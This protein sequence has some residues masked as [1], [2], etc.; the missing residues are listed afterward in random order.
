MNRLEAQ[1]RGVRVAL[2][3]VLVVAVALSSQPLFAQS[4][5]TVTGSVVDSSGGSL[6]G[7]TVVLSGSGPS[8][9]TTTGSD[10]KFKLNG[11]PPGTYK[12]TVSLSGFLTAA[13][14]QVQ[15]QG[16][17]EVPPVTLQIASRG[18]DIV[19]TASKTESS[20]VNAPVSISVITAADLAAAPV[21]NFGDILRTVPGMN[22]IQMSAR[23]V[24]VT[25]REPTNTLSNSQLALVDGRTIYLDF[26]GL[27]LW[28]F[29]PT[30]SDEIKQIEV[31]R[32]PASVVWGANAMTGVVNIIT[33]SPREMEGGSV[34]VQGG[35][36]SRDAGSTAGE[37]SGGIFGIQAEFAQAPSDRI[38]YR[39]GGGYYYSDAYPRPIGTVPI[40][41]NPADPTNVVG[42][43][44]YPPY[45][46]AG[47]KQPRFDARLDQELDNGGR[48][49]YEGGYAGTS[50]IINSG[51]GP[52]SIQP[53]SYLAFG[54]VAYNQNAFKL[55][56]YGNFVDAKAP[57]L[58]QVDAATLQPLQ[59]NFTTQ[60]YDLD[61]ENANSIG[62]HNLLTYGGNARRNNFTITIAPNGQDRNEFGGYVQDEIFYEHIRFTLG[63]RVDKF[64]NL[65][66]A[67]FSPRLAAILKP[68]ATQSIRLSFNKAFRSPSLIN[69]YID[70]HTFVPVNLSALA[71]LLPPPLQGL[72]AQP[73]NLLVHSAG[74][75]V[76]PS[77]PTLQEESV[78]AYEIGY[79]GSFGGKTTVDAAF[80]INDH[81]NSINFITDAAVQTQNGALG[82]FY[83]PE[84][85]P[86]GWQ[87]PV[88]L[89]GLLAEQGILLPSQFT[90][91]NL[92]PYRQKGIELGVQETF[93]RNLS[94]FV[95]YSY[96]FDP[97]ILSSPNP[98]PAEKLSFPPTNRF[99]AGLNYDDRR[100][101]GTL[102]VNYQDKAFWTDVLNDPFHGFTNSYTMVNG[103][104][105]VK[106]ADGR[107][108]T[109][110]KAQN[111]GN[112][113]IQQH[114]FGDIIKRSVYG[115]V[116][117]KF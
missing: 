87:L 14:D 55:A 26:F 68:S 47:T 54:R 61:A 111:I 28:D 43:G 49:T 33:K 105:G 10:G 93:T 109:S 29:V 41:Q 53:G 113:D 6:P 20:V 84:N 66:H 99:N 15:V 102:S 100:F 37:G 16:A 13:V 116:R 59:L 94:G 75:N 71:P 63:A 83:T 88:Q 82:A 81:D 46:N 44:P 32:G 1:R 91:L 112:T 96:Q 27:I 5:G 64:S 90:Y 24:N 50:G 38:S 97:E 108:I 79:T 21:Q 103:S 89:I 42:G 17:T 4:G 73:F 18:E 45:P 65:D 51:I 92:G 78:K 57:N 62:A 72:V 23:D 110:I 67:V 114:I 19:V 69:N 7:A 86:P 95:N 25:S 70:T 85:P 35:G 12:V 11:V 3:C 2:L 77:G 52:F 104:F 8:H 74:S 76:R 56:A 22:V 31:V 39:L 106:W 115:E 30:N 107:V 98:F 36:F 58:L 40:A 9:F 48:L 101:V 34:M 80:Y 60:T 117:F